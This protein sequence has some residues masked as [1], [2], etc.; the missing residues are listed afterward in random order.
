MNR[1]NLQGAGPH[2]P[3]MAFERCFVGLAWSVKPQATHG[4]KH[5]PAISGRG[6]CSGTS[7]G[8]KQNESS[9]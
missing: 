4:D 8:E 3:R 2:A 1:P 6:G 7:T 9:N 5:A